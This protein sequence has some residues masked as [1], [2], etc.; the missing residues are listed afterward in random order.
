MLNELKTLA[1]SIRSAGF[2]GEEWDDKLKEIK[3]KGSPCFVVDLSAQGE[4]ERIRFLEQDKA[5]VLRTWQGGSNGECFPSF[6]FI[7]FYELSEDKK[8]PL[9]PSQKKAAIEAFIAD[10]LKAG[11]PP[12]RVGPIRRTDRTKADLKTGKCLGGIAAKFFDIVSNGAAADDSFVRFKNAFSKLAPSDIAA[13]F[14]RK[15]LAFLKSNLTPEMPFLKEP[16]TIWSI[17]FSRTTDVVLFFD[18]PGETSFPI[19]SEK[20]IRAINARLLAGKNSSPTQSAATETDAFGESVSPAEL[21]GKLPEVK[22]PGAVA[23]TK[24]RSMSGES[25]CQARYGRVDAD[26]F[27]VGDKTRAAMK[28]ALAWISSPEREGKT[29]A[30]AGANE[31]VFAYPKNMPPAPPLLAR[32]FG[33]GRSST[34][35]DKAKE[36][37]FEKYAEEALREMK[38]LAPNAESNAEIEVFAIKKADTA[39]RKVVFYRNYSLAKLEAAVAA[40]LTGADNIPPILLRKWPP[41]EKGAKA[42]KGTKPVACEFRAPL[43]LA[44]TGLVYAMWSQDGN[45]K[46]EPKFRSASL[47]DGFPV[48]DG[49]ELFLGESVATG[50]AER[51]LSLL[52]Q[53]SGSLCAASGN[54]FHKNAVIENIKTIPHLESALPLFGILL[55]KLNRTKENYME[56]APYLIG[57]F[58]NLAD[59]LHK[60]WCQNV[61]KDD[62]LPPQLLGSTYFASFQQNPV[63]AFDAMRHRIIPYWSWAET[64]R[65][66]DIQLS[67]WFRKEMGKIVQSIHEVG[68]PRKLSDIDRAEMLLGY[69]AYS[70]KTDSD[71]SESSDSTDTSS[72]ND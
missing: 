32:L 29:W 16:P 54:L 44:A 62:P 23:N 72:T 45:E 55:H 60:V 9:T 43:P 57:R 10:F 13:T 19:A 61:K 37:R 28:S 53:G 67:R 31:L 48:F 63:Q 5:K 38:T 64:N 47:Y 7:P 40:W 39:R 41:K 12:D 65:T 21:A 26:S 17:L 6:N 4:I 25:K 30:I 69:L 71:E 36:A 1:D 50:L 52:L 18:C 34:E 15:M 22:L 27:P 70:Q 58:L 42:A 49:L 66:E 35:T 20:G 11:D 46:F 68:I 24:L 8:N 56:N 51:M 59:G 3:V 2:S 14:N 33:N